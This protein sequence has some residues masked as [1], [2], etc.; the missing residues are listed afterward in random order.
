MNLRKTALTKVKTPL[1]T[2]LKASSLQLSSSF[3]IMVEYA[4]LALFHCR[5]WTKWM[6]YHLKIG[7][8]SALRCARYVQREVYCDRTDCPR[9]DRQN[10]CIGSKRF[11]HFRRIVEVK[12]QVSI[13]NELVS[14]NTIKTSTCL[15]TRC[16]SKFWDDF[17][18]ESKK[19]LSLQPGLMKVHYHGY[20]CQKGRLSQI[21]TAHF[22]SVIFP[23]F[24]LLIG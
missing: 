3:D 8:Q 9:E 4:T 23:I 19:I 1:W 11:C 12:R 2:F 13:C 5:R 20:G 17:A 16:Q 14:K 21:P 22:R 15:F 6:K 18:L 10:E 7:K 24:P